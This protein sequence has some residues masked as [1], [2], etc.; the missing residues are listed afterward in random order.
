MFFTL[1]AKKL[2]NNRPSK[3]A[4]PRIQTWPAPEEQI[5]NND[6]SKSVASNPKGLDLFLTSNFD[7]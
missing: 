2:Y 7:S 3:F 5:H 6:F 1:Q 4:V